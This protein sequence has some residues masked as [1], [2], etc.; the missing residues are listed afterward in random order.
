MKINNSIYWLSGAPFIQ[1]ANVYA[2]DHGSGIVLIDC[3]QPSC[4]A[5]LETKLKYW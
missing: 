3:E 5:S 4:Y 1:T 2:I